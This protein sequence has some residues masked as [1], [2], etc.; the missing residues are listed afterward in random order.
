LALNSNKIKYFINLHVR[1]LRPKRFHQIGSSSAQRRPSRELDVR[2]L[3]QRLPGAS[4]PAAA[5]FDVTP[6]ETRSRA[7]LECFIKIY[8]T[9]K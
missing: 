8:N 5:H 9:L 3:R 2:A 7:S 6:Q 1:K 4:R